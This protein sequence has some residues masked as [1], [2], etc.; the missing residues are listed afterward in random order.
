[1]VLIRI[2]EYLTMKKVSNN[3]FCITPDEAVRLSGNRTIEDILKVVELNNSISNIFNDKGEEWGCITTNPRVLAAIWNAG[4]IEGIRTE[5]AKH[6][7][8]AY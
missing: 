4:I 1:M 5:R 2:K 3:S 6:K 7:R 8:T